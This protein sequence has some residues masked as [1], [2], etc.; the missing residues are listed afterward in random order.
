MS[1]KKI[2]DFCKSKFGLSEKHTKFE[3][4][5]PRGFDKSADLL[6]KRQN[7]DDNFFKLYVLLRKSEL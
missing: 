6:S 2:A 1:F 4:N 7:Q 3:K 5:L